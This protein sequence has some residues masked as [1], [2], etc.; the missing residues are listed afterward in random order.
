MLEKYSWIINK[1]FILSFDVGNNYE[2]AIVRVYRETG[3]IDANGAQTIKN[4]HA[5][6]IQFVDGYV[7]PCVHCGNPAQQVSKSFV[8][9]KS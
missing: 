2:F 4:A 5:G 6:G 8:S 7:Y 1:R 9:H 3:E